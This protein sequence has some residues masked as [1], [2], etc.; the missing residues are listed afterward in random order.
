MIQECEHLKPTPPLLFCRDPGQFKAVVWQFGGPGFL[1]KYT[2]D[3][4][5]IHPGW[6]NGVKYQ[7]TAAFCIKFESEI[8]AP[9]TVLQFSR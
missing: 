8:R 9:Q 5:I 2:N 4:T 1:K 6:N 7:L 3:T